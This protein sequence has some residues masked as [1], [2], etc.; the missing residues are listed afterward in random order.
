MQFGKCS[1]GLNGIDDPLGYQYKILS[2][3]VEEQDTGS[4]RIEAK[5]IVVAKLVGVEP[6]SRIEERIHRVRR[7]YMVSSF[8]FYAVCMAGN[9][10]RQNVLEH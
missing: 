6:V 9:L 2:K 10:H 3:D 4:S 5:E 1:K 7:T 8:I